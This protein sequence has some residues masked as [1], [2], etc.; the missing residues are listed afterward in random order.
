MSALRALARSL[1]SLELVARPALRAAVAGSRLP[2]YAAEWRRYASL[3]GAGS[4]RVRDAYPQLLDRTPSTP[5]DPHYFHQS[6]WAASRIVAVQPGEHVDVGSLSLFVGMLSA[7]VPVT[8]IDIRPLDVSLRGLTCVQGSLERLPLADRSVESLSCLHV[9]EHVGLG[10]YGDS[11][12]PDGTR[13]ACRELER[14]LAPAGSLYLSAPV[15]RER[16]CFNAHR[17]HDPRTLLGFVPELELVEFLVVDDAGSLRADLGV[18]ECSSMSYGCGLFR[19][20]R[21]PCL[22]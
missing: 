7:S 20:T 4:L 2:G 11:L 10:R 13:R 6:V 16:V 22:E 5:Y 19:L 21:S 15:G 14:V 17:I 8:F 9:V 3:P 1:P 18:D 12:D